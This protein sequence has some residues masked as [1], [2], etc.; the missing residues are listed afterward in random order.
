MANLD[1]VDE[2]LRL[3]LDHLAARL[4]RHLQEQ[5]DRGTQLHINH[6]VNAAAWP[7]VPLESVP[8]S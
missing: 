4:L 1:D 2:V 7:E 6:V 3:P 8:V 5:D